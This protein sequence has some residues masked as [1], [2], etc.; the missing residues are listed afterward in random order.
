MSFVPRNIELHPFALLGFPRVNR[1]CTARIVLEGNN[2]L[3]AQFLTSHERRARDGTA[4]RARHLVVE[5]DHTILL[6][7]AVVVG[8]VVILIDFELVKRHHRIESSRLHTA[9]RIRLVHIEDHQ[10][11]LAGIDCTAKCWKHDVAC[12]ISRIGPTDARLGCHQRLAAV[13]WEGTL[14]VLSLNA[15]TDETREILTSE[16]RVE[17][18]GIV[19]VVA[20]LSAKQRLVR[21][22]VVLFDQAIHFYRSVLFVRVPR[23]ESL[24][25]SRFDVRQVDN[26]ILSASSHSPSHNCRQ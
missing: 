13:V 22:A 5:A 17:S 12:R 7:R 16:A 14:I 26:P 9:L 3:G 2:I 21:T 19:L 24:L 18:E 1:H 25:A 23:V 4:E 8:E 11:R 6:C 15:C 10:R 20:Q